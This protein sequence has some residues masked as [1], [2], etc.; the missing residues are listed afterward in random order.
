MKREFGLEQIKHDPTSVVTVGTFDGVHVG[1]QAIIRYLVNRAA[2][3]E[4]TSVVVSF[5]PH[6]REIVHGED[7]P[8]LTTIEER[9]DALANLGVDRFIILPF[10]KEFSRLKAE[11]FVE[12]ILVGR[13][14]LQE[15]VIGYDH[16]FGR[17]RRGDADL[18][19]TLGSRHGFSVDVIPPQVVEEHVVSSTE[20][21][22][23]IGAGDVGT[24]AQL[25]NRRYSLLGTV[26]R[27]DGRGQEIGFP[28]ANL[29]VEHPRK[30]IPRVGV[31]A[32]KVTIMSDP[33][34][35]DEPDPLRGM[36]NIGHRPTFGRRELS[37]E[38]HLLD[39]SG[40]LYG[41]DLRVEFVERMRDERRFES[42]EALV[43]Q[44]SEDR[45]RC[46]DLLSRPA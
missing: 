36:M 12:D 30:V 34:G 27:G 25:L 13:I 5:S 19:E 37:L 42:K 41:R 9:A 3:K 21:R 44:L 45:S 32:V 16:A 40:D 22:E 6:P 17:D 2:D 7:V 15:V 4:G 46:M 1:H 28:T 31:Y 39:F 18:L 10:T 26:V 14:G 43:E 38:V 35:G 11:A 8:L 20:I 33:G 24:A 23:L 29:Q